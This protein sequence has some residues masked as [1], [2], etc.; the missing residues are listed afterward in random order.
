MKKS[1]GRA[2][3]WLAL[4][5]LGC[6]GSDD[7]GS[8]NTGTGGASTGSG[9]AAAGS[10][11]ASVAGS[12]EPAGSGGTSAAGSGGWQPAAEV[13]GRRR[14][15]GCRPAAA[16]WRAWRAPAGPDRQRRRQPAARSSRSS[17]RSAANAGVPAR[18]QHGDRLGHQRNGDS[19]ATKKAGTGSLLFY[20]YGTVK[21][22]GV[23][24]PPSAIKDDI[25]AKAAS[26]S[27]PTQR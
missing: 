9:G 24:S 8:M 4:V 3:A 12:G 1:I 22:G 13:Q 5:V 25:T 19:P 27:R 15:R 7:D 14:Q 2:M 26:S 21:A 10:G 20:F 6:A 23:S 18:H 17:R 16:A 11:G